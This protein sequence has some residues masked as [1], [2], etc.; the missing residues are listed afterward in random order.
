[1][2]TLL[3]SVEIPVPF[4][5]LTVW[6]DKFEEEFVR[7]SPYHLECKLS[8]GGTQTGTA[9]VSMKSLWGRLTT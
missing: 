5:K 4:E 8:T 7:W 6:A 3:E 9:S 1:M 2:I